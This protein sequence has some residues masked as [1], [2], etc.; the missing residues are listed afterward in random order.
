MITFQLKKGPTHALLEFQLENGVLSPKH[1]RELRP[2]DPITENFAH[3]GIILSGRGPV[4]LYG[5]LVHYYHP[6]RWVATYDPRLQG[7]VVV[8][9]H[10]PKVQVG[11]IIPLQNTKP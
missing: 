9:T 6:T 4:W 2:P 10:T 1:L 7:A 5:F 8:E 3:L 11:D